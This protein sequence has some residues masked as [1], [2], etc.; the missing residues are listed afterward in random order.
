MEI[1]NRNNTDFPLALTEVFNKITPE[2]L[3]LH[4]Q[5]VLEYM[6]YPNTRGLLVMHDLGTG[7]SIVAAS[8]MAEALREQRS[9]ILLSAKS[10]HS[11]IRKAIHQYADLTKQ[12]IT[13]EQ[14]D[15]NYSFVT[16]NA[17]NMLTQLANAGRT[18]D[19]LKKGKELEVETLLNLDGKFVVVDEAHNLFNAITNGS[20]NAIGFY[21][22]VMTARDV[23]IV[24]LTG[25]PVV[26]H[27][28]ELV[29]CF[30]MIAGVETLPTDWNDFNKFFVD[31]DKIRVRNRAKF[32]NR[33]TG[34]LSYYGQFYN[35]GTNPAKAVQVDHSIKRSDFPEQLPVKTIEVPMSAYQFALYDTARELEL[36]EMS[37]AGSQTKRLQKPQ[38]IFS[39]SY[40]RLSRQFSNFT[41]PDVAISQSGN[42]RMQIMA[43][44]IPST[45]FTAKE[46]AKYSPKFLRA[47]ETVAKQAGKG[48]IYSSFV[49]NAG[50]NIMAQIL[51]EM[52]YEEY[53]STKHGGDT[54]TILERVGG[55][56][57]RTYIRLTGE[58]PPDERQ[59]LIDAFN[60]PKNNTGTNIMLILI[61]GAGAEGLDLKAVQHQHILE[62]YWNWIRLKQVMG[63]S[64]RYKSHEQLPKAKRRVATFIYLSTYPTSLPPDNNLLKSEKTTD[65]TLYNNSLRMYAVI[66]KFYIAM[67]EASIDCSVHNKN[68]KVTCRVCNPTG[69]P[70]F[71]VD[72]G[73]DMKI[74][75]PCMPYN[76]QKVKAKEIYI[77]DRRYAWS[78]DGDDV[79][80]YE[81]REDLGGFTELSRSD[82][83][84]AQIIKSI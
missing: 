63:R 46:L 83:I 62:P 26:N 65:L 10:L 48:L 60:D 45:A 2:H 21:Q 22:A 74:R 12:E 34:L 20:S 58:T 38:G 23:K 51:D 16:M 72:F 11:N 30:N 6:A 57:T 40:R 43:D 25:T 75:S 71:E 31:T 4:Q 54:E 39:S 53:D 78:R 13:D 76:E 9:V 73:K 8:V 66:N 44:K 33:I 32:Q 64:I 67:A 17:S 52:G 7:K 29:P 41:P 80:V 59:P 84:Y 5:I 24:F 19:Q 68:D 56:K 1:P 28:F 79:S 47:A 69:E 35:A 55:A 50:I 61:S 42:R 18:A 81:Y 70:M 37:A 49:E 3:R 15:T 77:D 14:I 36:G 27:P 82:P